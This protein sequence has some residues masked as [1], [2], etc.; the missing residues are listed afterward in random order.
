[1]LDGVPSADTDAVE[2]RKTP[3]PNFP[4]HSMSETTKLI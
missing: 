2:K 3:A 1:M 4:D